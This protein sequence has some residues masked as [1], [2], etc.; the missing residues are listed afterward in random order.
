MTFYFHIEIRVDSSGKK[1]W[2]VVSSAPKH[3]N[4]ASDSF[5][6]R[7]H[8]ELTKEILNAYWNTPLSHDRVQK[9]RMNLWDQ[10]VVIMDERGMV[11]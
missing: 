7:I 9:E 8:A 1:R 4:V 10:I 5:K 3:P 11:L 2:A 6:L